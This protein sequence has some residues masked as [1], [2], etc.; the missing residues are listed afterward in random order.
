MDI[1]VLM[2]SSFNCMFW[3]LLPKEKGIAAINPEKWLK[4]WSECKHEVA[5]FYFHASLFCSASPAF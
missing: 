2:N 5:F 1:K 4:S 3:T